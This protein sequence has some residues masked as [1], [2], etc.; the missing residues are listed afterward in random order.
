MLRRGDV[1]EE[2]EEGR[3]EERGEMERTMG[4][5]KKDGGIGREDVREEE[6][7]DKQHNEGMKWRERGRKDKKTKKIWKGEKMEGGKKAMK[8]GKKEGG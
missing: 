2:G 1:Q 6:R 3:K 8:E 4:E 5:L 7:R